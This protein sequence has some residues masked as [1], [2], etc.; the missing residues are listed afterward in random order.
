MG[1]YPVAVV[2]LH[3]YRIPLIEQQNVST[4][5]D[6]APYRENCKRSAGDQHTKDQ[7]MIMNSMLQLS[8]SPIYVYSR[9][10]FVFIM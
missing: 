1:W 10:A 9:D 8:A 3:V 7:H 2:I 6:T 4:D 5:I